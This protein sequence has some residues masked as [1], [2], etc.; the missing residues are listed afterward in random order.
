MPEVVFKYIYK[1]SEGYRVDLRKSGHRYSRRFSL[2]EFGNHEEALSAAKIWLQDKHYDL[3]EIPLSDNQQYGNPRNNKTSAYVNGKRYP[4]VSGMYCELVKGS[5]QYFTV[6][7]GRKKK[8]YSIKKLGAD[9]AHQQAL[10]QA[11]A[12]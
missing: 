9:S 11:K 3:F 5:P 10:I 12:R 6:L 8:R 7:V 2:R 4:L 1:T